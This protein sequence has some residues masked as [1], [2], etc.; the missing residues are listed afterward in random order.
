MDGLL[1]TAKYKKYLRRAFLSMDYREY[2]QQRNNW[3]TVDLDNIWWEAHEAAINSLGTTKKRFIQK[4]IHDKLPTNYR[5]NKLYNYRSA[6]CSTC[7]STI[8]TQHHMLSCK[9]CQ[10]REQLQSKFILDLGV[11]LK[12]NHT[13][14][15][16][17]TIITQNV[18]NY[19]NN[20]EITTVQEIAPDA[21]PTL[22][23]AC[24]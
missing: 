23:K 22:I 18:R 14:P 15:S 5:K 4:F 16:C 20:Q 11:L 24:N 8:E 3:K 10:K 17:S 1:V 12:N 6:L 13:D 2:L 21:S 19:L 9:G 7:N